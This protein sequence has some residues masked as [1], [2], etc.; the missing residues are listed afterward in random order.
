MRLGEL[1]SLDLDDIDL[2]K[3]ENHLKQ[4]SKRSN[5]TLYLEDESKF[6]FKQVAGLQEESTWI[7]RIGT[8]HFQKGLQNIKEA[9]RSNDREACGE[10]WLA[11]SQIC[12]AG[13]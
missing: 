13:G 9:Y 10:D 4:K 12:K 5:R 2:D 7:R 6:S 8:V 1:L 3:G 11:R